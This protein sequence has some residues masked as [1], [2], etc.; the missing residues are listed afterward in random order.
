MQR[1]ILN[2]VAL[3]ATALLIA[4]GPNGGSVLGDVKADAQ[5]ADLAASCRIDD[6]LASADRGIAGG[7][8]GEY[9]G[10]V[11]KVA[12]LT[13]ANRPVGPAKEAYGTK[14]KAS[15][16][17]MTKFDNS[18]AQAIQAIQSERKKKSGKDG[19]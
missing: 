3:S 6:A 15:P 18:V 19:C 8:A 14:F 7:G 12:I 16:D 10:H 13:D 1:F 5:A 9:M 4:C 2:T 11:V 17:E